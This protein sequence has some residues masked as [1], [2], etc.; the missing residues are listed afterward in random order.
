LGPVGAVLS[1]RLGG[2]DDYKEL[3]YASSLC[4]VCKE[5]WQVKIPFHDL[6][7]NHRQVIVETQGRSPLAKKLSM[8]MFSRG[9]SSAAS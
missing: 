9:A 1:P 3:P 2:Y 6:L 8:N 4:G 5:D 7:L